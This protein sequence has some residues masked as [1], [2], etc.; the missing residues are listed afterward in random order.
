MDAWALPFSFLLKSPD[1][2]WCCPGLSLGRA[3]VLD[4]I[5]GDDDND[6]VAGASGRPFGVF[7]WELA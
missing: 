6:D 7:V 5:S 1:D 4:G 2:S 3:E